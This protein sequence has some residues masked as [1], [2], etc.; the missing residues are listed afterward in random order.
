MYGRVYWSRA[1]DNEPV[2]KKF[3]TF[4]SK[5]IEQNPQRV[6]PVTTEWAERL[7]ALVKAVDIGNLNEP[8]TEDDD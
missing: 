8:L 4:L 2:A 6:K 7:Q 5:E 1:E 3:L